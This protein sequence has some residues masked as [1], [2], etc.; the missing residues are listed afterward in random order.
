[1]MSLLVTNLISHLQNPPK[2]TEYGDGSIELCFSDPYK[3]QAF[4]LELRKQGVK[5]GLELANL[6]RETA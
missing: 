5:Y 2:I 1:M 3:L 4:V 6:G